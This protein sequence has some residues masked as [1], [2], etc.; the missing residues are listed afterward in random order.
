MRRDTDRQWVLAPWHACSAL[1]AVPR[2]CPRGPSQHHETPC[3]AG[4][5]SPTEAAIFYYFTLTVT[6]SKTEKTFSS[7]QTGRNFCQGSGYKYGRFTLDLWVWQCCGSGMVYPGSR[8]RIRP[9]L[10]PESGSRIR[11]VKK[12]RIPDPGSRIRGVKKHRIPDPTV[13]KNRNEK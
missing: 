1:A 5:L 2:Q 4:S 3:S 6:V 11:G 7:S 13:H 8:I 12:H 10:H 9:L